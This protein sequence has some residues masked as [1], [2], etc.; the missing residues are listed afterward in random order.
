MKTANFSIFETALDSPWKGAFY[1]I[2]SAQLD[3]PHGLGIKLK[4]SNHQSNFINQIWPTL[5]GFI[6]F[7]YGYDPEVF[8]EFKNSYSVMS[9]VNSKFD[10]C[11]VKFLKNHFGQTWWDLKKNYIFR[12]FGYG[13]DSKV[14]LELKNSYSVMSY[15]NSKFD[16]CLWTNLMG[17]QKKSYF[18]IFHIWIWWRS[19]VNIEKFELCGGWS[20]FNV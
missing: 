9:Y 14:F 12:Y 7:I 4:P 5:D 1:H 17:M 6:F 3:T 8:L 13:Y 16:Y 19:V 15:V 10:Y 11:L 18:Y 2:W 20:Q